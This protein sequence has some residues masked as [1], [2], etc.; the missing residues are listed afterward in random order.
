MLALQCLFLL[1]AT[2]REKISSDD[3]PFLLK[4][5][6]VSACMLNLCECT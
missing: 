2:N 6:P 5:V 1:F 4:V 3:I